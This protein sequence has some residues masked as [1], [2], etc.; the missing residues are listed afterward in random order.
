MQPLSH[1]TTAAFDVLIVGGG[2]A[3]AAT[4]IA[5]A[6]RG[7][8]S[9]I[10]ERNPAPPPRVGETLPPSV[11]VPLEKLGVWQRFIDDHHDPAVGNRSSWGSD[12]IDEIHFIRNAYGNGWHIDRQKFE[13]MLLDEAR[14]RGV[15]IFAGEKFDP[16]TSHRAHFVVDAT[17]RASFIARLAGADRIAIDH[18]IAL[19]MFLEPRL[20]DPQQKFTLIEAVENGWWY[21]APLPDGRLVVAYMTDGDLEREAWN[22]AVARTHTTRERIA[23]YAMV[24][25]E[26]HIASANTSRLNSVVGNQWLAAGDAATAFDPLS[27]QG[28]ITALESALDAAAAIADDDLPRYAAIV[29]D[30]YRKYLVERA[31]YYAAEQ[32]WPHS[33]FWRR[34]QI[35]LHHANAS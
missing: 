25:E 21:S 6:G 20:P 19:T 33:E 3:G 4:A 30:R 2:P 14:A 9:A 28:I 35:H 24:D 23:A 16:Q 27:S 10:V 34:R 26:P 5:L 13:A 12:R 11:R 22:D 8:N 29:T 15:K 32:R 18:L 17:G 31:E 7:L 1:A